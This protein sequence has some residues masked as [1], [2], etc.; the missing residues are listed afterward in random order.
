MTRAARRGISVLALALAVG[1]V[2]V[3]MPS[4][5]AAFTRRRRRRHADD[6][7]GR[8]HAAW[9]SLADAAEDAGYPLRSADSP[10]GAARRLVA[11]ASLTGDPAAEVARLASAEERA[12]YALTVAPFDGL[13]AGVRSV[14]RAM[15]TALPRKARLRA[16]V[17]PAS[18]VRRIRESVQS[19]TESVDRLRDR[20]RARML[21]FARGLV[22]RRTKA[23]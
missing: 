1:A 9:E 19:A 22:R 20:T 21:G 10:R 12:R 6:H 14:R 18:A 15:I 16:Q 23:A 13:D 11:A 5:V 3:T 7:V 4:V 2:V 8:I 17:F